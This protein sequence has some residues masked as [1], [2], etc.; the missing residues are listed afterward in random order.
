MMRSA[1]AALARG[2][3]R[4]LAV[5]A[6]G[7]F[8]DAPA[9]L[10]DGSLLARIIVSDSVGP[11]AIPSAARVQVVPCAELIAAAIRRLEGGRSLHPLLDPMA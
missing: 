11:L 8:D 4:V 6:H 5:A 3:R 1:E 7:L 10:F 2:A 9:R